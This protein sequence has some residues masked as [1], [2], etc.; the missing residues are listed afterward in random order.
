V[1]EHHTGPEV[2][3]DTRNG[4]V[5][6]WDRQRLCAYAE[7]W[8]PGVDPNPTTETTCLYT[9]TPTEDFLLD[10]VGPVVVASPCSGHGFKFAPLVGR[11]I[12]DLVEGSD[13]PER[14]RL[15]G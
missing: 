11:I 9:T 14:F 5:D 4:L 8:L 10:R 1:A 13:G 2:D 6:A 7:E 15:P 12:A 3:A